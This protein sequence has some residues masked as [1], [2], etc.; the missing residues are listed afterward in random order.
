[1]SVALIFPGQ[2]GQKV[3]SGKD[4]YNNFSYVK[5]F[6]DSINNIVGYDILN[7]I[8][9]GTEEQ[10]NETDISQISIIASSLAT[11]MVL[12]N[13]YGFNPQKHSK[14]VAGHSLGEY[15]A[16][17]VAGV[18][19]HLDA[20]KLLHIRGRAM[21]E[22]AKNAPGGM[23]ALIG[24][25]AKSVQNLIQELQNHASGVAVIANDNTIGQIVISGNKNLMEKALEIY[26]DF[27]IKLAKK[28]NVAGAFHSPLMES[29]SIK[30]SEE[31]EKMEFK[32]PSIAFL[33]NVKAD[34]EE[35]EKNIKDMLIKQTFG[36][37]RWTETM[38]KMITL[39]VN[40]FLEIGDSTV[41]KG[42]V[43]RV[44]K[45]VVAESFDK[46]EDFAKINNFIK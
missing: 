35:D 10:I 28:L 1:M 7:I 36:Q 4:L 34:V 24:A 11:L 16:L 17:V 3:G 39:G 37:V 45:D 33:P 41:L 32:K 43:S 14:Y 25:D 30:L 46:L 18:I 9:N 20:V 13:E 5:E 21:K 6:F 26:K 12:Q 23:V 38:Q 42:L 22:C 2:G 27:G 15:S 8:F 44:S 29:A 19:T 40:S 31:L